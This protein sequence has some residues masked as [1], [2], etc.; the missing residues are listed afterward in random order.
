MSEWTELTGGIK[1]KLQRIARG[2][3]TAKFKVRRAN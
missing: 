1:E 2:W 3:G